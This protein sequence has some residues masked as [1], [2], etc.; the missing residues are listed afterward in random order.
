M[1]LNLPSIEFMVGGIR[2]LK[3]INMM[4]VHVTYT[5]EIDWSKLCF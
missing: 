2:N 4:K 5:F 1:V 3:K